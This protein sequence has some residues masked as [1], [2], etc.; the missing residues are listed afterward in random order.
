MIRSAST[1]ISTRISATR[2]FASAIFHPSSNGWWPF[3][4]AAAGV[5]QAPELTDSRR[6]HPASASQR[7]GRIWLVCLRWRR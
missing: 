5:E 7:G 2:R 6:N 1:S 3:S 4:L